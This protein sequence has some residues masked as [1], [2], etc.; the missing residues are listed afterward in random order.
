MALAD[1][2][3]TGHGSAGFVLGGWGGRK[4][5]AVYGGFGLLSTGRNAWLDEV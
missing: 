2:V 5:I 4:D 1:R 3:A